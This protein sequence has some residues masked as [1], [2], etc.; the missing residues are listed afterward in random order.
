MSAYSRGRD[1]CF[2][3]NAATL[4]CL[5]AGSRHGTPTRL[6]THTHQARWMGGTG[7]KG[8]GGG[9]YNFDLFTFQSFMSSKKSLLSYN[10][11]MWSIFLCITETDAHRC[12]MYYFS[13]ESVKR[14]SKKHKSLRKR[15]HD[16]V[17]SITQCFRR[18][19]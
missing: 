5:V 14:K 16:F 19:P 8:G 11:A 15:F 4:K 2:F 3:Y 12:L 13:D 9:S 7:G 1:D 6:I 10:H 18:R 17:A